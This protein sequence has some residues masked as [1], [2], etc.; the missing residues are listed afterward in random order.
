MRTIKEQREERRRYEADVVYETWRS[1]GDPDR[2]NVERTEEHYYNGDSC[3]NAVR[4][5]L[6]HQRPKSQEEEEP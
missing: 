3:E 1:G 2:V 5:E 4:D 6:R